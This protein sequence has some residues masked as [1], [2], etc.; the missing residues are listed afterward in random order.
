MV[1]ASLAVA[2]AMVPV[3]HAS[4]A[5]I[6][7]L[8]E[9]EKSVAQGKLGAFQSVME[10]CGSVGIET[11]EHNE[12]LQKIFD[13]KGNEYHINILDDLTKKEKIVLKAHSVCGDLPYHKMYSSGWGWVYK[14]GERYIWGGCAWQC[15]NCHLV[16]VTEGDKF[17]NGM[18]TIGKYAT[19]QALEKINGYGCVIKDA[20]SYGYSSDNKLPGYKFFYN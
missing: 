17:Y 10:D 15:R 13:K 18:Q 1:I 20:N 12:G 5:N 8:D 6:T 3:G 14:N 2:V 19:Y 9:G 7:A 11:N 16:I 4:A